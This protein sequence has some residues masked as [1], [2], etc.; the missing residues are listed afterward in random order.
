MAIE[1]RHMRYVIAVAETGQL[2]RAAA[3]LHIAQPALSQSIVRLEREIGTALFDRHPRGATPTSAG[4]AFLEYARAAVASSDAAIASARQTVRT[5]ADQLVLG[6]MNG[7]LTPAQPLLSAFA[8]AYDDINVVVR[9][10][11]FANQID[12]LRDG[13]VDAAVLCPGPP[14]L[15]FESIPIGRTSLCVYVSETHHL[16]SRTELR[17]ADITD[18]T[19]LGVS[20]ALPDWWVDIWWL[21][22]QR[23][24][25]ARTGRHMAGTIHESL[26]G[27][28]SGEVIVVAPTFF[29]LDT[30]IPGVTAIPLVDVNPLPI[31]VV[32]LRNRP[33]R[34]TVRLA[35]VART[36]QPQPA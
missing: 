27:V 13:T 24:G 17:F 7:V 10:L 33:T 19:F 28:L 36:L 30:P 22:A 21:T 31:E 26:A 11:S 6:F 25:P 4:E 15:E 14:L 18:E 3:R 9:E 2:T 20:P 16:A 34:A 8:A 1:L 35:A 12:S 29:V 32:H 5:S 23:G